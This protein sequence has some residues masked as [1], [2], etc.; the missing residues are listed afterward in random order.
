MFPGIR[1]L[2]AVAGEPDVAG[3]EERRSRIDVDSRAGTARG[4]NAVRHR[5][6]PGKVDLRASS[7]CAVQGMPDSRRA[8]MCALPVIRKVPLTPTPHRKSRM[9]PR[10]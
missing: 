6:V 3:K 4:G 8:V 1:V 10:T 9:V 5:G 2:I 7:I